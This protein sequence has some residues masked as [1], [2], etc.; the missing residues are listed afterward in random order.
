MPSVGPCGG[1]QGHERKQPDRTTAWG[2]HGWEY[3]KAHN[4]RAQAES[5]SQPNDYCSWN[6]TLK[7]TITS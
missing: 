5:R 2:G 1:M 4:Q 7:V 3:A 6:H